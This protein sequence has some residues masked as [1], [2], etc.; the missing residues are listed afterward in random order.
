MR[1]WYEKRWYDRVLESYGWEKVGKYYALW[2]LLI[3]VQV[4]RRIIRQSSDWT[5]ILVLACMGYL[6]IAAY[7]WY[8][9]QVDSGEPFPW[10]LEKRKEFYRVQQGLCAKCGYDLR[11]TPHRCPECGHQVT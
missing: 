8:Q 2:T 11:A 7:S 1:P 4:Y 3:G 6:V 9:S 10:E 5:F